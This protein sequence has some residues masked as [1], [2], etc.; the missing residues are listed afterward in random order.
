MFDFSGVKI[1]KLM[2]HG[3]GNKFKE[4]EIII[5]QDCVNISD[6]P[7][8][9]LLGKYFFQQFKENEIY[10]FSH[11]TDL[12]YNEVYQFTKLAFADISNFANS[13]QA[14]ARHLYEVSTHPNIKR[15]ELWVV[16]IKDAIFDENVY[17]AIGIF[18]SENKD[19]FI[20]INS[21][22][23]LYTLDW[24]QGINI[25]KL[26][27]GCIIFNNQMEKGFQVLNIDT[28][29]SVDTKYW[30]ESFL[31]IQKCSTDYLKTK[32]LVEACKEFV[33][34]DYIAEQS[35]KVVMLNNVINYINT[36]PQI[37]LDDFS[38]SVAEGAEYAEALMQHIA[39]YAEMNECLNI[40]SFSI[41]KAVIKKV[42]RNIKS[43]IKL[44]TEI[45]IKIKGTSNKS[46]QYLEKGYDDKKQ[47]Y[48]YKV[49]FNKEE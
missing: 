1:D 45:E 44:D 34:K 3:V 12:C 18:K 4:E 6:G 15:G 33:K 16:Y 42:K 41:D 17:D 22:G 38:V 5:S 28:N 35:E 43:Y 14:I 7:I 47:M 27:K 37:K 32:T 39:D 2:L 13:S 26:D 48:Y 21:N 20:R 40:E 25:D 10:S 8:Y 24:L 11:E 31:G 46:K 19:A 30:T 9:G 49:Y 29:R 23:N 36:V